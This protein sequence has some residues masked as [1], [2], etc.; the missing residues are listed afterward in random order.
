MAKE[1][2]ERKK[3]TFFKDFKDFAIRGNVVDLAVAVIM[4]AAFGKIVSSLVADMIMPIISMIV[5][6]NNI[7]DL[8]WVWRKAVMEGETVVKPEV[9][10]LYGNFIQTIIDFI[11]IAFCIFLFVRL[12]AK[13]KAAA[14][15]LKAKKGAEEADAKAA[16]VEEAK[17]AAPAAPP[18]MSS[19][20]VHELKTLLREIRDS[21]GVQKNL[22]K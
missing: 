18:A 16:A 22:T 10:M 2:K 1:K 19:Q 13:A 14:D 20:D 8:K 3:S 21:I 12:I 6:G 5:G 7:K 9:A 4:G 11:C 17:P 15:A